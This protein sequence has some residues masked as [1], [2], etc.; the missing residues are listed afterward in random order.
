VSLSQ[1]WT[2][3]D[4]AG[5]C[6]AGFS[7]GTHAAGM[8]P[9]EDISGLVLFCCWVRETGSIVFPWSST[10]FPRSRRRFHM[11]QGDG[12]FSFGQHP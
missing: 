11:E 12:L 1:G 4:G 10:V 2:E 3:N 6:E 5:M 7:G 9:T 8:L